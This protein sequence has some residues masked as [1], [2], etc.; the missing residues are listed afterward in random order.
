MKTRN[1]FLYWVGKEYSLITVLRRLI[2][3]HSTNGIGYKIHLITDKNISNYIKDIPYYFN[4]LCPAHQADFVR[5]NVICDYGGIWLDSDTL[6]VDSLDKL[7]DLN[8]K[9]NG[10]FIIQWNTLCNGIF[11]SRA[12]TPLMI[13]WKKQM[14][15][16]LDIKWTN[17][18]WTDIGNTMLQNMYD[19]NISLYNNYYIFNGIENLYPV[20]FYYNCVSEF[21]DK[22]YEN[23]K[24]IIRNF[25]PLI[26]LVNAVYKKLE[27]KTEK[28]ILEGNM[29]INYFI[30][31]SL[32]N[33]LIKYVI[34]TDWIE[35]YLTKEPFTFVKNL[36]N[37]GW[38]I[39]KLSNINIE[40]IKNNKSIVLCVTYDDFDISLIK[41]D[42]VQI[43]YKIDNLYPYK[44]IR[45]KCIQNADIIISPYQY[46][47]NTDEIN[48][49]YNNINMH[50]TF[51]IPYSAVDDFFKDVEF[52]NNPINKIFISGSVN[53]V[54]LLKM[55]I[56]NNIILK[57]YI[58]YL[59]HPS[60]N[61]YSHNCINDIYYKKLN[62]YLCCF[63]DASLYKFILLKVFEIC[64]VGSL[65]LVEDTIGKNL[66][67]LGFYD[68][69]NCIFCNKDNLE[70]KIKW[71]LNSENSQLI[72]N[73]RKK[74]MDL[75]RQ[76]HTTKHRSETFN[77]IFNNIY[78]K[79]NYITKFNNDV[80]FTP[81][82][83]QVSYINSG[84]AEPYSGEITIINDYIN[85]T[86]RNNTYLDIGVNIGTHSI[87]YS[88]LFNNII[89]FEP[90]I[91]NY[92][93]SK[94]NLKINNIINVNLINKS[95]GSVHG[96]VKTAQ[97]S[98][99][100]RECIYTTLC[101]DE[102]DI[103]QIT[104]DSLNL[105]DID[106][107][108]MDVEGHE[109]D[110]IKGA[111]KTIQRNKPIL[112]FEYNMLAKTLYNIEYSEIEL[113]LNSI[114]YVFDKRFDDNY[115][116]KPTDN[117]IYKSIF[118]N[119]YKN[120][121]WNNCDPTIPLSGPGSS[122]EN[123]NEYS[124]VLTTFIYDNECKIILDLGCGDLTWIHKTQFFN[125][126]NIKYI[127]VDIVESLI[128]SHLTKFPEKQ[129]LCKD[130]SKYNYFDN[131]DIIII[132]D[133]IFH[134]KNDDIL[135]IFDNIKNKFKF[136]IITSCNNNE[137]T[138]NFN[139]WYFSEKNILIEPF[140]KLQNFI[141]KI[142][143]SIFN[144]NA[145]IYSHDCFYNL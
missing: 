99:H 32:K 107:I 5:I 108:K 65:L 1:L 87:V 33:K 94:E 138:D 45:N 76:N 67:N 11:G 41:C 118:E 117:N 83:N 46:L 10:F 55:F 48:K 105:N 93:Q 86:K 123:T 119:I 79:K 112:E 134:L 137:N 34:Y 47:F 53:E 127:G 98:N 39:I 58:E 135:S 13:E 78:I 4:N 28:E 16:V 27:D 8:E 62:E 38:E 97:H 113:Y 115:F 92:N 132:R 90:D 40:N 130:I 35:T 141:I 139:K 122:I 70:N 61:N 63:V 60:Y 116:Y 71:I 44:E 22:P 140:N 133:V 29:P 96:F 72:D 50:N 142:E 136:L 37:F 20:I 88:K 26:V 69:I 131:V 100:S 31:K 17:L 121:I 75:V 19:T 30:N 24:E 6:V 43:I 143:E 15:I 64:S 12:K 57:D 89:A 106:F 66:N 128:T 59:I 129:F 103:E 3:L 51:H 81:D 52:N 74:G 77:N 120:Q 109:L 2:Y 7:F 42:N 104:L 18:G 85:K 125:D 110:I 126:N 111:V 25:Q 102:S 14:R 21:I 9:N 23:Y 73:M 114:D 84:N 95:L 54:Y 56:T 49:M 80:Y 144:R 82:E 91:Y 101:N 124:K 68:N 36:E 145:F